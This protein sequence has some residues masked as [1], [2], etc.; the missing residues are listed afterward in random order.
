MYQKLAQELS[1]H[2]LKKLIGMQQGELNRI[3]FLF[4]ILFLEQKKKS[5]VKHVYWET[6]WQHIQC[7][8]DFT[9]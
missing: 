7:I 6:H 5:I 9:P 8:D 1:D 4:K 3:Q 2:F